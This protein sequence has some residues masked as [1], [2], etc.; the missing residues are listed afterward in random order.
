MLKIVLAIA[1]TGSVIA[2]C[3]VAD[4]FPSKPVSLMMPYA[5]GGPGDTITRTIGQGMSKVLGQQFLA[6]RR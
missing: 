2:T 1:C 6:R 4:E 5:A 3:A